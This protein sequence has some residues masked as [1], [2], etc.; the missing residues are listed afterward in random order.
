MRSARRLALSL[1]LV[2]ECG[3]LH[4]WYGICRVTGSRHQPGLRR[5]RQQRRAVSTNDYVELFN[6]GT[7]TCRSTAGRS[8]TRAP[9]EP[10]KFGAAATRSRP[11]RNARRRAATTSSV[12]EAVGTGAPIAGARHHRVTR[13]I[14]MAAGAGKVALV[15]RRPSARAATAARRRARL[16]SLR[17][18]SIS[19]ATAR[20]RAARTSSRARARRRLSRDARR[21]PRRRRG[22][23]TPIRTVPTSPPVRRR[24]ATA[25]RHRTR[26]RPAN[27]AER[28]L[29]CTDEHADRRSG[30]LRRDDRLQRR[31]HGLGLVVLDRVLDE[32]H[33][34]GTVT[35]LRGDTYTLDPTRT[36]AGRDVQCHDR[37]RR[38]QRHGHDRPA[39]SHGGRSHVLVLDRGSGQDD[40]H[41]RR[42]GHDGHLAE[43]RRDGHRRRRRR[44]R[45]PGAGQ[46]NG[47]Y[48]QEED[49][50]ADSEPATSEG[51][52]VFSSSPGE[53]G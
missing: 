33:T 9:P 7:S 36:S 15:D 10:G 32:R 11:H 14:N 49:A 12:R 5:R 31:R 13:P 34:H 41:P 37:R 29:D 24:R 19:S 1:A 35:A 45:L 38:C 39:R 47:F 4:V 2:V 27:R 51:I 21:V 52:F 42:P 23:P 20:A 6:R 22:A 26:A 18:S 44:R 16:R 40:V 43:G 3:H 17:T 8:S 48:V 25:R 30:Q 50:D 46:F 53:H 28:H